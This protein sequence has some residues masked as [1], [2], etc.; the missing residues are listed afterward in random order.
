[1]H[2]KVLKFI[3]N[4]FLQIPAILTKKKIQTTKKKLI[5]YPT[6]NFLPLIEIC[7]D[8]INI[9]PPLPALPFSLPPSQD[10]V[11][12][13]YTGLVAQWPWQALPC[14]S[15]LVRALLCTQHMRV[16]LLWSIVDL[17]RPPPRFDPLCARL[18]PPRCLTCSWACRMSSGPWGIVVVRVS[19]LRH[20]T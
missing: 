13:C 18:S 2:L 15:A 17:F 10:K 4:R 5:N 16:Q 1:M 20:P 6:Y 8:L 11:D 14:L 19:W 12:Q 7:Q 9:H 3:K